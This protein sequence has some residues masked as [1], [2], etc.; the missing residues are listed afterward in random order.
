MQIDYEK[1]RVLADLLYMAFQSNGIHGQTVMPEDLIP[2][3][4]TQGSREH[5]LFITLTVAIDYQRDAMALWNSSRRSFEDPDTRYL[6]EPAEVARV[7]AAQITRDMK[8]Y[9]LSKK[10]DQDAFIW[11]TAAVS[12]HKKYNNDPRNLLENC[13]YKADSILETLRSGKHLNN[14]RYVWDFPYLRG[15][16]IGPLWVRMLRDNL[17]YDMKNMDLI[18][19][20]VD[21]HVARATMALGV[22]RGKYEGPIDELYTYI[23]EAWFQSVKGLVRPDGLPMIALDVDEPLWHLS[24]SGCSKRQGNDYCPMKNT[25]L[26][27][28]YCIPG[29]IEI[30]STK[31]KSYINT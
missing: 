4:I 6:F 29:M 25:C 16:K 30:D 17:G 3:G 27:Q 19:I 2:N 13:G 23:R 9:G 31:G 26:C 5:L 1:G 21:I 11:T 14:G 12:F 8:K 10:P 28:K 7:P 22:V 20:P 18:P 15:N 24:R